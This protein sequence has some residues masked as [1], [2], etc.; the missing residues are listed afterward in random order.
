MSCPVSNV[1]GLVSILQC[2]APVYI[3]ATL[4]AKDEARGVVTT[5]AEPAGDGERNSEVFL[6]PIDFLFISSIV[7]QTLHSEGEKDH[8][9]SVPA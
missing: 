4:G 6:G 3:P 8:P 5:I 2:W 7:E 9:L 1:Q